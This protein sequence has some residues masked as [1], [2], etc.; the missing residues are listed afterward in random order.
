MSYGWIWA[1]NCP[2]K[3]TQHKTIRWW[4]TW[5]C[6][7]PPI[8]KTSSVVE[9]VYSLECS[10]WCNCS[11]SYPLSVAIWEVKDV[12]PLY[13]KSPLAV[14]LPLASTKNFWT[15]LATL[16]ITI[17]EPPIVL[18]AFVP[19]ILVPLIVEPYNCVATIVPV[20]PL[21]DVNESMNVCA[22]FAVELA[23]FAV[24]LATVAVALMTS[25]ISCV[26]VDIGLSK[27]VVLLI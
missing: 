7:K 22:E 8:G 11:T 17:N 16:F 21:P 20:Y 27:S 12:E 24:E 5:C 18:I 1:T 4:R 19:I 23:E 6:N 14:K 26:A 15:G 13:F 2:F 25:N 9:G 3:E 10:S